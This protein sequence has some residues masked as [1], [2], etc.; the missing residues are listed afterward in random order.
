[1]SIVVA[2]LTERR[3]AKVVDPGWSECDLVIYCHPY[4]EVR[5]CT[6]QEDHGS[7][8]RLIRVRFQM[9]P[10][11]PF[12]LACILALAVSAAA[13]VWLGPLAAI[14]A[15][16]GLVLALAAIWWHAARRS[17]RAVSVFDQAAGNLDM[18]C[19]EQHPC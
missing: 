5:A 17:G 7:G 1:L 11:A 15:A 18:I 16:G 12:W 8:R 9:R 10:R 4:T 14:T 6:V 13:G 2:Y 19:C 3:W